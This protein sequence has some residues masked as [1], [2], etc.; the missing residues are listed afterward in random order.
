MER[1]GLAPPA[2]AHTEEDACSLTNLRPAPLPYTQCCPGG[3][4]T[5]SSDENNVERMDKPQETADKPTTLSE[6]EGVQVQEK[7]A[8]SASERRRF[9]ESS[10]GKSFS[11]STSML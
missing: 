4:S 6:K 11:P 5:M 1:S 9:L 3:S 10:L 2:V 7:A 8:E